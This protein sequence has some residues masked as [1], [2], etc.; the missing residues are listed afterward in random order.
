MVFLGQ[1][2]VKTPVE[3]LIECYPAVAP[4]VLA[5]ET[6]NHSFSADCVVQRFNIKGYDYY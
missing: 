6:V 4:G 2:H 3:I 5:T 1:A